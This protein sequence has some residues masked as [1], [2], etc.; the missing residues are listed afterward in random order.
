MKKFELFASCVAVRGHAK[1]IIQDVQEDRFKPVPLLL[2]EILELT[3]SKSIDEIK[4]IYHHE[5]DEGIDRYFHI[6]EDE[7]YGFSYFPDKEEHV[8]QPISED[9]DSPG[10]VDNCVI[11][12]N[13]QFTRMNR[14]SEIIFKLGCEKIAAFAE[15]Q[16]DEQHLKEIL[17]LLLKRSIKYIELYLPYNSWITEE[18]MI[19]FIRRYPQLVHVFVFNAPN[20]MKSSEASKMV[21]NL[22]FTTKTISYASTES[23]FQPVFVNN[24]PFYLESI[25]FNPYFHK[26]LFFGMDDQVRIAF[27]T[28]SIANINEPNLDVLKEQIMASMNHE[29]S[30]LSKD[31]VMVCSDCEF[32]RM[33]MDNR[34][35]KKYENSM[36]WFYESECV[37]NPYVGAFKDQEQYQTLEDSGV[38]ISPTGVQFKE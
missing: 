7:N 9:F 6:L 1:G 18:S 34:I 3:K 32:R 16:L 38:S 11:E 26:K 19:H 36:W 25:R 21:T 13:D 37:Y 15:N 17:S 14:I 20:D 29:I 22:Q 30:R 10:I 28:E 27:N 12:L 5:L 31:H 2:I 8:F 35:P 23:F 4:E 24:L 33:C